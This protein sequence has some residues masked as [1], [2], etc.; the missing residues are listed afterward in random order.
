MKSFVGGVGETK[1]AAT[2]KGLGFKQKRAGK[3]LLQVEIW[4][5][6][7]TTKSHRIVSKLCI[8]TG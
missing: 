1:P 5:E 6:S 7:D 8:R 3:V 4:M 2:F